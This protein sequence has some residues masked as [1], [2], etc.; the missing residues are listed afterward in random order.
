MQAFSYKLGGREKYV[1]KN[2]APDVGITTAFRRINNQ[3]PFRC[4]SQG[5]D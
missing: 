3:N 4:V 5:K 1:K 2:S